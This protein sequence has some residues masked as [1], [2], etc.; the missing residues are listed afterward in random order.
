MS[1][2]GNRGDSIFSEL[3]SRRAMIRGTAGIAGGLAL[4]SMG[5]SADS[6][7]S[8]AQEADLPTVMNLRALRNFDLA[9]DGTRVRVLGFAKKGDGGGGTF[10]FEAARP[11]AG[12]LDDDVGLVIRSRVPLLRGGRWRRVMTSADTVSAGWF[13]A[14][15]DGESYATDA[16]V[17]AVGAAATMKARLVIPPGVYRVDG[18]SRTIN[19]SDLAFAT[20]NSNGAAG[21]AILADPIPA[22]QTTVYYFSNV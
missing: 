8:V 10:A 13:G 2:G 7:L 15:G 9:M 6:E 14:R 20:D 22:M 1:E 18:M 5:C 16:L 3:P 21:V 19:L 11:G 12:D 4:V 17:A